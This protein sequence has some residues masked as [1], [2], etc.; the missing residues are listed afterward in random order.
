M[1]R[2]VSSHLVQCGVRMLLYALVHAHEVQGASYYFAAVQS[3]LQVLPCVLGLSCPRCGTVVS[4]N[5]Y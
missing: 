3:V 4:K 5:T 2:C 1:L